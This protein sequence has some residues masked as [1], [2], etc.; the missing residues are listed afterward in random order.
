MEKK[1]QKSWMINLISL[2]V[3]LG[4]FAISC[5]VLTNL[6]IKVY[7]NVVLSNDNNFELRTSLS[8]VATKIRQ[9]DTIGYPSIEQKDGVDV[10]VLGEEVEGALFETRIYF[11]D[12]SLYEIYQQA[13]SKYELDFGQP[14]L[15]VSN[16]EFELTPKGLIHLK[17]VN[18]AGEEE[19]LSVS[20][21]TGR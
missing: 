9:T 20:S 6:G 3:I 8:Y 13:G 2:I 5:L 18:A 17:A 16:F 7:R 21:R 14:V 15:D 11:K 4:I 12:G 19:T 10:L 1:N